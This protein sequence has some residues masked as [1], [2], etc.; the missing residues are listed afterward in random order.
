MKKSG[1]SYINHRIKKKEKPIKNLILKTNEKEKEKI[2]VNR[3]IFSGIKENYCS[4]PDLKRI[5][6]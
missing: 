2:V 5:Q 3:K 1:S 4:Q 6:K